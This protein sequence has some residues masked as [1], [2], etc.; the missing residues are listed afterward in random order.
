[1]LRRGNQHS[2]KFWGRVLLPVIAHYGELDIAKF[3][4][5]DVAF[6]LA[7]LMAVLEAEGYW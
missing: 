3:F 6:A 1:M 4:R 2:A 7:R 5:A